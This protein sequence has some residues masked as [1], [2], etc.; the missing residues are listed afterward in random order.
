M[1]EKWVVVAVDP[2]EEGREARSSDFPSKEIVG[3]A[4]SRLRP[5][6]RVA[7]SRDRQCVRRVGKSSA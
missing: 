2:R 1:I 3:P 6:A 4:R 7:A 5:R